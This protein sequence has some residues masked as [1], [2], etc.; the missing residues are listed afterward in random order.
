MVDHAP[1]GRDIGSVKTGII[2]RGLL[3]IAVV[4]VGVVRHWP[5]R[6]RMMQSA[7]S[8]ARE[9]TVSVSAICTFTPASCNAVVMSS[10]IDMSSGD[11]TRRTWR[12]ADG[13]CVSMPI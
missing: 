2:E 12:V 5:G 6:R 4:I 10:L 11:A 1:A 3:R 13:I 8:S 9:A 7:N